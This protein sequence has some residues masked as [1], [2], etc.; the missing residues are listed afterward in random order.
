MLQEWVDKWD[1]VVATRPTY[2]L[3][4]FTDKDTY[5]KMDELAKLQNKTAH[6]LAMEVIRN[7]AA[8]QQNEKG[9]WVTYV[10]PPQSYCL[11]KWLG[12]LWN[13]LSF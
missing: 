10:Y 12:W 8:T 9:E 1:G 7:Y 5:E 2:N 3:R 6:Q 13:S 11:A 4:L